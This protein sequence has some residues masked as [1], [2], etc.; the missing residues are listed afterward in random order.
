M[1]I[2]LAA[3]ILALPLTA[4]AEG[5]PRN[6][7]DTTGEI[8]IPAQPQRIVSTSPSLTGILLA[9]DAPVA[10]TASAMVGP[11]TDGKGFFAQ[12]AK[13]ADQRGVEVLYPNLN[14]DIEALIV[15]EPDLVVASSVGGDSILPYLDQLRAQGVPVMVLDYT[16][17]GWEDLARTL[18]RATGHEDDATRVT[19]DFARQADEA[20]AGMTLPEGK[21]SIVSYNFSGTY[22]VGKPESPQGRVLAALGFDIAG[23]PET[24]RGDISRS[25]DFDFVS[26]ENLPAA[27]T[28]D[29]IFLLNGTEDSVRAFLADSV[30]ANLPAVREGRVYPLGPTSFR[31]DYYSGLQIIRTVAPYF[32][33]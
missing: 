5:W 13:T 10:A 3:L 16:S 32:R 15:Q 19:A 1:F 23:I 24:M 6:I 22:A 12:W 17:D 14:F 2:R 25:A 31:V 28:G 8:S 30:L 20:R 27:I 33:K 26:H 9:I 4:H 18:G 21:A 29:S 11:L 7:P